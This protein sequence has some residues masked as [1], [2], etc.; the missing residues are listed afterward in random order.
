MKPVLLLCALVV[1]VLT[2]A[3]VIRADIAKPKPAP[4]EGK[5]IYSSLQIVPD[6]KANNARLEIQQ[7]VFTDLRASIDG[8]K[9]DV[10]AANITRSGT[11]TIIAGV[12]LFLSV[13][14][15]GVWLAR[16]SRSSSGFAR[17]Q[18][19][20]AIVIIAVATLGAAAII[21]RGNAGPP[22]AYRWRTLVNQ[23]AAGQ[24]LAGPIEVVVVP[25][26][27]NASTSIRLIMPIKKQNSK[28]EDE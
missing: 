5:M 20:V 14:F 6:P 13:S 18:K 12:L 28:G 7:S 26:D 15:A 9:A 25:D 23:L 3:V 4:S 22:P 19:A 11:R 10:L 8:T 17:G 2:A 21:T 24:P 27:P 1:V 16:A